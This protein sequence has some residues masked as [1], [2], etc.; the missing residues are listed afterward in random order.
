MPFPPASTDTPC[1]PVDNDPIVST[2]NIFQ[3]E[4]MVKDF[5]KQTGP[6]SQSP[7][8]KETIQHMGNNLHTESDII[9]EDVATTFNDEETPGTFHGVP[10]GTLDDVLAKNP[11]PHVEIYIPWPH[12]KNTPFLF[13]DDG[14]VTRNTTTNDYKTIKLQ[15]NPAYVSLGDQHTTDHEYETI[16]LQRKPAHVTIGNTCTVLSSDETVKLQRN[17]AYVT[18]GNTCITV[19][20]D[21]TVKLQRNPAYVTIGN[22]CT[23][24]SSDE[25]VKL[26]RNPAYVTIGNTCTTVSSDETLKLQRN[27]AYASTSKVHPCYMHQQ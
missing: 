13:K 10:N 7:I 19:S 23:T 9:T 11:L 1:Q 12:D 26:Q 21:E 25:T 8:E 6:I 24:V 2:S 20:S 14:K 18:I 27:P 22:T 4:L 17:P 16:P 3:E 15:E 5:P